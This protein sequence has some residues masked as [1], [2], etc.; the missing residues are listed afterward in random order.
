LIGGDGAARP[1]EARI[2]LL[3]V[4]VKVDIEASAFTVGFVF[5][6]EKCG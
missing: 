1:D 6:D 3:D 4:S 2:Y 5:A